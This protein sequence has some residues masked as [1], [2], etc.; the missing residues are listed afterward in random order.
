MVD[1]VDNVA[2]FDEAEASLVDLGM[3]GEVSRTA[4]A[5]KAEVWR[6][7]M[8]L[9]ENAE[10]VV[11]I[12]GAFDVL[13]RAPNG[14][15][16]TKKSKF[17]VSY[18]AKVPSQRNRYG[19]PCYCTCH[20]G[21]TK[22]PCLLHQVWMDDQA[23]LRAA[24]SKEASVYTPKPQYAITIGRVS[25]FHKVPREYTRRDGS[26]GTAFDL[27]RCREVDPIV[28]RENCDC[29]NCAQGLERVFGDRKYIQM[30]EG[31][32]GSFVDIE[33]Q[34]GSVCATCGGEI[35]TKLF[36]CPKCKKEGRM[37]VLMD[38]MRAVG[39]SE[40]D[41]ESFWKTPRRCSC[42]Y[43]G[44]PLEVIKCRNQCGAPKRRSIYDVAVPIRK[45]P[46]AGGGNFSTLVLAPSP[47][48]AIAELNLPEEFKKTLVPHDFNAMFTMTVQ[49]Q[50]DLLGVQPGRGPSIPTGG[51]VDDEG[52]TSD[53]DIPF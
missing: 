44:K 1:I 7:R 11:F 47:V 39:M 33:R 40:Q 43:F 42:G 25:Y 29:P 10:Y 46:S 30:G 48:I 51:P 21:L 3:Q 24:G 16:V 35:R 19:D 41:R 50:S 31:Y 23:R 45:Q 28:D 53:E 9:S 37:T 14:T 52:G 32:R 27:E 4:R 12:P 49:E 17:H 6:D 5:A 20:N 38:P 15:V 22:D 13:L 26:K 2:D 36:I 8:K 18:V 34:V